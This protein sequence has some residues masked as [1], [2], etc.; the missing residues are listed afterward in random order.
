MGIKVTAAAA[1]QLVD[2]HERIVRA[3]LKRGDLPAVKAG[4]AWQIDV[5]ALGDVPGWTVNRER[6][7][8]LQA[9]VA[10]TPGGVL[11]RLD[12]LE[13]EV[14]TLRARVRTLEALQTATTTTMAPQTRQN[15]QERPVDPWEV[16]SSTPPPRPAEPV[17]TYSMKYASPSTPAAFRT[18]ADAGRWLLRHGISSE[19]TPKT[20]PGW[21]DVE[22]DPRAVLTLALSLQDTSN[23]RILWRLHQCDD[24]LCVCRELL[25]G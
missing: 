5:D 4:N 1:A 9:T 14:Q 25:A 15:G 7:A 8:E 18:R 12:T 20:W 21:R 11:A 19:A 3:H 16:E 13:R 6:L 2:R 23:W 10:R 17:S 22:L 24:V